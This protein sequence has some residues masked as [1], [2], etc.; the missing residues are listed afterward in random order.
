MKPVSLLP[1]A[2]ALISVLA[3]GAGARADLISWSSNWARAPAAIPADSPGTGGLT[4][5]DESTHQATGNSD[6]VATN[7]RTFSSAPASAPDKITNGAYK[8]SLFLQDDA[9]KQSTT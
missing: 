1:G 4:L 3:S 5:T 7:I 8:L 9:S 2:L 6:I